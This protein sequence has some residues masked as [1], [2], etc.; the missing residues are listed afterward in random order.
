MG[1]VTRSGDLLH[2]GQLFKAGGKNY[3]AKITHVFG[4]FCIG[5]KIF[6]F[7]SAIIFGQLL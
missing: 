4:N 5:V 7:S 1:S 3:F 6:L 2:F